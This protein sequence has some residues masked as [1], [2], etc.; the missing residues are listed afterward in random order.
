M[1]ERLKS[2]VILNYFTLNIYIMSNYYKNLSYYTIFY[3]I[4]Y[5]F[6]IILNMHMH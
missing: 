3:V 6:N 2:A 4:I 5:K 1:I